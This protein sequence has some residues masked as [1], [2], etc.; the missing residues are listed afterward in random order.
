MAMDHLSP[1]LFDFLEEL[2]AHNDKDW[3]DAHR[4]R[5]Q[6]HRREVIEFTAA[7]YDQLATVDTMP[8]Q[9]PKKSVARIN[10]NRKFHPDKPPYKDHFGIMVNRGRG[11]AGLYLH[12]HPVEGFFGGGIY[13]P[14]RDTLAAIR[15][16]IDQ[17]GNALQS[18]LQTEAFQ[19]R[20]GNL[21]D[22]Q[23]KVAPRDYPK[24]H[25]HINLLRYKDFVFSRSLS[26]Q[27]LCSPKMLN[28]LSADFAAALPF[29]Q[30]LDNALA[31][32]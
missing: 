21:Q 13:R 24:D 28:E 8:W 4:V 17:R 23:L 27:Q 1:A 32:G 18:A 14:A 22:H 2:A 31:Q 15:A 20:F 3:L 29:L 10:N 19:I 9:D 16:H 6:A 25:P 7:L 30:F 11:K 26:R 5:Y 12:I